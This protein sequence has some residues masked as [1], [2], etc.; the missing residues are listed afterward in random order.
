MGKKE[1][2]LDY[3]YKCYRRGL[4]ITDEELLELSKNGYDVNYTEKPEV[5]KVNT[6]PPK[7]K[8]G[9]GKSGYNFSIKRDY[10]VLSEDEIMRNGNDNIDIIEVDTPMEFYPE[11]IIVEEEDLYKDE[12]V[13]RFGFDVISK[14]D[15][16]PESIIYHT[17]E[18]YDWI[19]SINN[20]FQNRIEYQPFNRYVQQCE[21]WLSKGYDF[22]NYNGYDQIEF[23]VDEMTR[24][25][26]N[27]LYFANKYAFLQE[28]SEATGMLKYIA[29]KYYVH[30][31]IL[32]Y[33]LDCGYSTIFGKPRQ[34]G[35]T[36]A[37]G[38]GA[39]AK[40]LTRTNHFLKFITEDKET[41]LEIF[42]DKILFVYNQMPGWMKAGEPLNYRENLFKISHSGS[43][44]GKAGGREKSSKIQIVAPSKTA[45][46]GGSPQLVY[47]DEI[48]SIPILSEMLNEGR[49]T[50]FRMNKATGLLEQRRQI[51]FWGTGTSE[52]GG[53]AY[54]KEWNRVVGLWEQR[55]ASVGIVPLFFD[56]S[57]RL[58]EKQ[59]YEE[60]KYYYG[61]RA[62]KD[63]IDIET[64]KIQFHQH[65]PSN[66]ADMFVPTG[67]TLV[68]RETIEKNLTKI[69]NKISNDPD[70]IENK[71][72]MTYGFFEPIYDISK[73]QS[74]NSDVPYAISGA[75][76]IQTDAYDERATT[77]ILVPPNKAWKYRFYAGTDPITTD[78][79]ASRMATTIWDEQLHTVAAV[80]DCK[81]NNDPNYS[82]MQSMLLTIYYGEG[83]EAVPEIVERNIGLAYR[84]YRE[85]KGFLNSLL[86]NAQVDPYFQ[87]GQ[88]YDIGV[89]N[90]GVRNTYIINRLGEVMNMF[91][92]NIYHDTV[93]R[94][95]ATF[96]CTTTKS[97][98]TLW[99]SIDK[100]YY[101]DDVLFGLAYAYICA[102][103]VGRKPESTEQAEKKEY[104]VKYKIVLDKDYNLK[105]V[106]ITSIKYGS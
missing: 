71:V 18:F 81:R 57:V 95:L 104:K 90:R 56:W 74:E 75:N 85:N 66:P 50:L 93:F 40:T 34:I 10:T 9:S 77:T 28:A 4:P 73:P 101:N 96:H 61:A 70:D 69:R 43:S 45:I 5:K 97:G 72:L 44:K 58:N 37:F 13:I 1:K 55:E 65:Y 92:D 49:P 60:K 23:V 83:K 11:P 105:R 63:N 79:G 103:S 64:S 82:F 12:N 94:Q 106:P 15:W 68:S 98:N 102:I 88:P 30:H 24:I 46:N 35:S 87:S 59:Y 33:L 14:K 78:T 62:Q 53:A 38:I 2:T 29:D 54:E 76:F 16:M 99:S 39:I 89:D 91:G 41:G 52:K 21:D 31:Q 84:N 48:G 51:I 8:I 100:R 27:T 6:K 3:L 22:A 86:I 80:T 25:E 20:G 67:K 19:D 32:F 42:N 36:S 47:V 26:T 17:K 7:R